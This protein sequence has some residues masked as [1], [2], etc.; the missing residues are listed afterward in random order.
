LDTEEQRQKQKD[1]DQGQRLPVRFRLLRNRSRMIPACAQIFGAVAASLSDFDLSFRVAPGRLA[2]P[3][4]ELSPRLPGSRRVRAAFLPDR[5]NGLSAVHRLIG[6]SVAIAFAPGIRPC[7]FRFR[8]ARF[9]LPAGIRALRHGMSLV[10]F[11]RRLAFPSG[12][13]PHGKDG[14][15]DVAYAQAELIHRLCNQ[16]DRSFIAF[17]WNRISP[18]VP[19]RAGADCPRPLPATGRHP[20]PWRTTSLPSCS[21][22]AACRNSRGCS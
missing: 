18:G 20:A 11:P 6:V 10:S 19:A 16:W 9:L 15:R 3:A 21:R 8:Y 5:S 13:E 2:A 17:P 22:R 4:N 12:S 7:A 14:R 1:A